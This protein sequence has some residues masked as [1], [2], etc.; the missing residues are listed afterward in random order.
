V[1][2]RASRKFWQFYAALPKDVQRLAN[3]NYVLLKRDPR[4]PSL[5]FKKAGRFW[6]VRIGIHYRTAAVARILSGSGLDTIASMTTL[7]AAAKW[8]NNGAS[9]RRDEQS[10]LFSFGGLGLFP[11]ECELMPSP[12]SGSQ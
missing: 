2:H 7:S 12:Q 1:R 11:A 4:H 6:S 10:V 8:Q 9:P 3:A 5:H